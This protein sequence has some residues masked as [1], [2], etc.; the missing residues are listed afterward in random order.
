MATCWTR[1]SAATAAREQRHLMLRHWRIDP[2]RHRV[3]PATPSAR[4]VS[5]ATNL[6]F[7]LGSLSLSLSS[8]FLF[9][10]LSR[11]PRWKT[12]GASI[13][14]VSVNRAHLHKLAITLFLCPGVSSFCTWAFNDFDTYMTSCSSF[15]PLPRLLH[16]FNLNIALCA[17]FCRVR[18]FYNDL[19]VFSYSMNLCSRVRTSLNSEW[20]CMYAYIVKEYLIDLLYWAAGL[21]PI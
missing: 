16:P 11:F 17:T 9:E 12:L 8:L 1:H 14:C 13:A 2:S 6:T 5:M 19:Q 4:P 15:P 7:S 20:Q 21:F 10:Y 3:T 18:C